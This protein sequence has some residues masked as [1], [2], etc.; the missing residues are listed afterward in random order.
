MT[1]RGPVGRQMAGL[2]GRQMACER[3]RQMRQTQESLRMTELQAAEEREA[4]PAYPGTGCP[5]HRAEGTS[6]GLGS[7]RSQ[8]AAPECSHS[9]HPPQGR[10]PGRESWQSLFQ[11]APLYSHQ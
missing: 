1:W 7:W 5:P 10:S 4:L 11:P 8:A 2:V 3:G 6:P 9:E